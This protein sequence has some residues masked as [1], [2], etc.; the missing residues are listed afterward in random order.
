[1][2]KACSI[3]L[4]AALLMVSQVWAESLAV[5]AADTIRS[6]LT[7]HK[8]KRVTVKLNSG[9][10]LTGKVGEVN[11]D[12]IH[13]MALSGKEYFDAVVSIGHIE[14]VVIRTKQ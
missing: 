13:L 12:I 9:S 6:I 1:M 2:K 10:E 5:G 11:D 14:A 3:A 4:V 7:A 8:G